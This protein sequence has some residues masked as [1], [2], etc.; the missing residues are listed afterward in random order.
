MKVERNTI[1][2]CL[3]SA[4]LLI[5]ALEAQPVIMQQPTNQVV[6][7]GASASFGVSVSGAGTFI[8]QWQLNGTNLPITYKNAVI[9]TVAGGFTGDGGAATNATLNYPDGCSVDA[10]DNLFIA[11]TEHSRIRKVTTNGII[12]TVA[13]NGN[14]GYSQGRRI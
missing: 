5:N 7:G 9:T 11:D 6:L 1:Q 13:G 2:I 12:A 3:L 8:Y 10:G 14:T 4:M